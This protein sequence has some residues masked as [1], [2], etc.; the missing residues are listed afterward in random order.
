V[1]DSPDLVDR[2]CDGSPHT[3]LE[4]ASYA[5]LSSDEGAGWSV[6]GAGDIDGDGL[7]DLLIGTPWWGDDES[8]TVGKATLFLAADLP[9]AASSS[10]RTPTPPSR[11]RSTTP[12]PAG[13]W[14]GR[15]TW[16]AT[17]SPTC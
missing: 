6:A 11:G 1:W 15:A 8:W 13:R 9:P 4:T 12:S 16:T 10:W 7:G 3:D 5:L 2:N 14:R 17:A